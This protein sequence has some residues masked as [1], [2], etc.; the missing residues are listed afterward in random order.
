MRERLSPV[1][2]PGPAWAALTGQ[3]R[4][5]DVEEPALVG[6]VAG[7]VGDVAMPRALEAPVDA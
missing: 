5:D 4:F 3:L 7:V 6:D 1:H 2:A